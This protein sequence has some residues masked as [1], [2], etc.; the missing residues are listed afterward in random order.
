MAPISPRI[1]SSAPTFSLATLREALA[2][3]RTEHPEREWRLI[4]AANIVA[5]RRI[6]RGEGAGWWVQSECDP[7][8]EYWVFEDRCTCQ[9]YKQRGGPCKHALAV[10][11]YQRC[12]RREAEEIDPTALPGNPVPF[13]E[14][15]YSDADRFELT[16][17]G[18][19]ILAADDMQPLA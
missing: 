16:P 17:P 10:E 12:E 5:V 18:Y 2:E 13:P 6:E 1:Q 11:L 7:T 4:K 3:L 15:A 14:R 9:D 19:A 8:K